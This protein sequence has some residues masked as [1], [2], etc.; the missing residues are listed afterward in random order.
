MAAT[1]LRVITN[2]VPSGSRLE[3]YYT[4][5]PG[6]RAPKTRSGL[7]HG[8]KYGAERM[9][10]SIFIGRNGHVAN[11]FRSRFDMLFHSIRSSNTLS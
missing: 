10:G 5:G 3:L 6:A 8:L 11:R 1:R 4:H 9:C 7:G 2:S